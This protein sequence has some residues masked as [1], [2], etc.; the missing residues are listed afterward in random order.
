VGA[1]GH[2]GIR[3]YSGTYEANK[4]KTV[5]VPVPTLYRAWSDKRMRT[6]WLPNADL[7]IHTAR[8]EQS[9]R[10]MWE[11]GTVVDVYFTAK[12]TA[13]SQVALQH[14]KLPSKA[15]GTLMKG[16]WTER[17]AALERLLLRSRGD[18]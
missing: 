18:Q 6:R 11:D 4:S 7:T 14:R 15:V 8:R 16:Y 1:D 5:T 17:L 2:G 9:M 3:A 13:K 12:G 10:I